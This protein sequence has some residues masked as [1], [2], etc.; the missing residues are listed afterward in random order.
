ML[1]GM[2]NAPPVI[3]LQGVAVLVGVVVVA[4][5]LSAAVRTVVVPRGEHVFLST[6]VFGAT[7]WC[8][9]LFAKDAHTYERRDRVMSRFAPTALMLLP[10]AWALGLFAGFAPIY[11]GLGIDSWRAAF[12]LSGSSLTTLGFHSEENLA[13]GLAAIAEALLGLGLVALLI[14]FLP[15]IYSHFSRRETTVAKLFIRAENDKGYADPVTLL[16]RSHEIGGLGRLDEVWEEWDQWFVELSESHRSF[17][18]LN[19]FRSPDPD[20]SWV[21]G[22]GL[23][24]DLASLYLS[25]LEVERNPRAALAVRSGFLALRNLCEFYAMPFDPD[26]APDGPISVTRD[27]FDHA[28][29]KLAT[30]GLPMQADRD[31]AWAAYRGWRVNYD[32]PLI[33]LA[34]FTMAPYQPWVSDRSAGLRPRTTRSILRRRREAHRDE[35]PR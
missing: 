19:F 21:T 6:L 18:S 8:F 2:C 3:V 4:A 1:D 34:D 35:V 30:A 14:S 28:Y 11:W 24:L 32:V 17:P 33:H 10:V 7:R 12:L 16:I 9:Q 26:P 13:E 25:V 31:A 20:R 29:D 23:L 15:T 22:A 27:E 5:V